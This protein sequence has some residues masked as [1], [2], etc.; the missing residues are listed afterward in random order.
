[1]IVTCLITKE[2]RGKDLFTKNCSHWH[3]KPFFE[4]QWERWSRYRDDSIFKGE[5]RKTPTNYLNTKIVYESPRSERRNTYGCWSRTF[6]CFLPWALIEPILSFV[7]CE[8]PFF[9][10]STTC[11][12]S[13]LV[14]MESLV[15]SKSPLEVIT[16]LNIL[17]C[18]QLLIDLFRPQWTRALSFS[19]SGNVQKFG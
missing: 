16:F 1:M 12:F 4:L 2:W 18:H 13:V 7:F 3:W 15:C 10:Q 5:Y 6:N 17:A 11:L 19:C 8:S 14:F 9:H